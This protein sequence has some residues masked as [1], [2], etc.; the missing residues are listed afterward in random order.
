LDLE[1]EVIGRGIPVDR[2]DVSVPGGPPKDQEK[3]RHCHWFCIF[4]VCIL[5]AKFFACTTKSTYDL[6]FFGRLKKY[7]VTFQRFPMKPALIA[8][9]Q[10]KD[11]RFKRASNPTKRSSK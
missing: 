1:P 3:E 2:T 9:E 11:K 10:K 8:K 6:D 4:T 7:E 5:S